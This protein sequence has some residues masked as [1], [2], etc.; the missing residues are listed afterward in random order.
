MRLDKSGVFTEAMEVFL[1]FADSRSISK[2][3]QFFS[4]TPSSVSRQLSFLESSLKADLFDRSKRP[5]GLTA[6]GLRFAALMKN[7]EVNLSRIIYDLQKKHSYKPSLRVGFLESFVNFSTSFAIQMATRTS[8]FIC[9]SG[10]T[11]RLRTLLEHRELDLIVS[12][13]PLEDEADLLRQW[14]LREPCVVVVPKA[15]A[16]KYPLKSANWRELCFS[17]IP[18][19]KS[20][21]K[22][23]SAR[24]TQSYLLANGIK[25]VS[26]LE[27]DNAGTKLKMIAEGYGWGI[28]PVMSLYEN[29][30]LFSHE[31]GKRLFIAPIVHPEMIREVYLVANQSFGME[32]FEM[33]GA[34]L[35]KIFQSEVLPWFE[36]TIPSVV[37][38]LDFYQFPKQLQ[39]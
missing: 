6:E 27:F 22:S 36:K 28:L 21:S 12:S 14:L 37:K 18:Y 33:S 2:T 19:I 10:T 9:L 3:A 31:F 11:D 25:P 17:G 15:Y 13:D 7:E 23:S 5:I 30:D 24:Q 32:I 35:H 34:I 8:S 4:L 26:I 39:P 29:R 16:K 38:E 20:Y 1:Y